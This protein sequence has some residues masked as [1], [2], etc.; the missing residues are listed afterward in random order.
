[1]ISRNPLNVLPVFFLAFT[2]VWCGIVFV[3]AYF[4]GWRALAQRFRAR[5]PFEGRVRRFRHGAFGA[6][7]YNGIL[8]VG[9]NREG[10]YLAVFGP[11]R[12]FTPPLLIPWSNVKSIRKKRVFFWDKAIIRFREPAGLT[13]TIAWKLAD[14]ARDFIPENLF[15]RS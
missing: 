14:E 1:M 2:S 6:I 9:F 3:C 15:S 4:S 8:V 13:L 7:N 12:L 10:I 11:Y 5:G